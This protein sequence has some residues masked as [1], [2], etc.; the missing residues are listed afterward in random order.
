MLILL[1]WCTFLIDILQGKQQE[2]MMDRHLFY[3]LHVKF[4]GEEGLI[5]LWVAH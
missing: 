5:T 1:H 2:L 3:L 4:G